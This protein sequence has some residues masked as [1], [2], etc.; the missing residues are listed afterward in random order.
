MILW[1]GTRWHPIA[2]R[3]ARAG[4]YLML[5]ASTALLGASM[6]AY[7]GGTQ[8]DRT[9]AGYDPL[10]NYFCDLIQPVA[11]DGTP[12][13]LGASLGR[14]AFVATALALVPAWLL[15]SS[16][17]S[18]RRV[19]ARVVRVGG[20]T[21][22]LALPLVA[23]TPSQL[24]GHAHTWAIVVGGVP[25]LVAMGAALVGILGVRHAHPLLARLTALLLALA[26][27]T[28]ALWLWAMAGGWPNQWALATAQ[29]VTWLAIASWLLAIAR[30]TRTAR[31]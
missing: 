7:H 18:E 28:G 5:A 3:G 19:L 14:A 9:S 30:A 25:A 27:V 29:K 17:F 16:L 4:V 10:R 31:P 8:L 20:V 2:S 1:M 15:L 12:N 24:G 11:H 6:A 21:A 13:P 23:N 22:A 26:S